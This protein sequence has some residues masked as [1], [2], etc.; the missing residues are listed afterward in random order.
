MDDEWDD[1]FDPQTSLLVTDVELGQVRFEIGARVIDIRPRALDLMTMAVADPRTAFSALR[2]AA[3]HHGD[4]LTEVL[5]N[6]LVNA[7]TPVLEDG[8]YESART[9]GYVGDV[10][11]VVGM[12]SDVSPGNASL[13]FTTLVQTSPELRLGTNPIRD[14]KEF[15]SRGPLVRI[16]APS[17]ESAET[18][19]THGQTSSATE[20]GW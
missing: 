5:G 2:E 8:E 10:A 20:A 17:L 15:Y 12:L 14:V 6:R 9:R 11:D 18:G 4:E 16:D 19:E 7:P 3:S 1:E 13:A